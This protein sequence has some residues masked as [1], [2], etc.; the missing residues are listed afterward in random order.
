M[1]QL[2]QPLKLRLF[3]SH[4]VYVAYRT[5]IARLTRRRPTQLSCLLRLVTRRHLVTLY[6]FPTAKQEKKSLKEKKKKLPGSQIDR[7]G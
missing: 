2:E 5:A 6:A 4:R 1:K 7:R 3:A